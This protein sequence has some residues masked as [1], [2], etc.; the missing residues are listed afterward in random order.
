MRA[1]ISLVGLGLLA[2][3]GARFDKFEQESP[4]VNQQAALIVSPLDGV[5]SRLVLF[6]L[7]GTETECDNARDADELIP[8]ACVLY[9][10]TEVAPGSTSSVSFNKELVAFSA[11]FGED[12][13]AFV[14]G[15]VEPLDECASGQAPTGGACNLSLNPTGDDLSPSFGFNPGGVEALLS[16]G[17]FAQDTDF[18][19]VAD[20]LLTDIAASTGVS[21]NNLTFAARQNLDLES[22]P[23]QPIIDI[24]NQRLLLSIENNG[25]Q[26][27]FFLGVTGAP[28]TA[29]DAN[30]AVLGACPL[31]A[32]DLRELAAIPQPFV[33]R[34]YLLRQ[35]DDETPQLV[36]TNAD[37]TAP[38]E[39]PAPT[40]AQEGAC[41]I[42]AATGLPTFTDDGLFLLFPEPDPAEEGASR[43]RLIT[44][45]GET[46]AAC[47]APF[48]RSGGACVFDVVGAS[49]ST[50]GFIP[51]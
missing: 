44:L 12:I 35:E 1:G 4:L 31:V 7:D 32:S 20:A 17:V 3:C 6:N 50:P 43:L 15:L 21:T 27:L 18:D 36:F 39:C 47:L 8:S 48:A 38:A 23:S 51:L 40:S 16:Q 30:D 34:L 11:A 37:G 33:N 28:S 26:D 19:G 41:V 42:S 10:L 45:N 2:S 49:L 24:Q 5:G 13:E 29:C 22:I 25:D 46:P 14:T 9:D